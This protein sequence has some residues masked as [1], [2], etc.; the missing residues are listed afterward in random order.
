MKRENG[1]ASR[2]YERDALK[3][4]L[5]EARA[6]ERNHRRLARHIREKY[7]REESLKREYAGTVP[8]L[9]ASGCA[10]R[11]ARASAWYWVH[12]DGAEGAMRRAHELEERL[13][14]LRGRAES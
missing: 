14:A 11:F 1:D 7:L 12:A 5:E 4:E 13:D 8:R 9:S 2:D 10:T 6:R 3:R